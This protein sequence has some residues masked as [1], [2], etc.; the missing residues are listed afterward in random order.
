MR[1]YHTALSNRVSHGVVIAVTFVILCSTHS[2]SA[3]RFTWKA[4]LD[5]H[6]GVATSHECSCW[7]LQDDFRMTDR[8]V[9]KI[10][11]DFVAS[12]AGFLC[13]GTVTFGLLQ[14]RLDR[15]KQTTSLH[16]RGVPQLSILTFGAAHHHRSP[17]EWDIPIC[18]SWLARPDPNTRHSSGGCLRFKIRRQWQEEE[19]KRKFHLESQIVGY[20]PWLAGEAPVSSIRK[21]LYLNTQS[22]IHAYVTYRFH[23]EWRRQILLAERRES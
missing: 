18:T 19:P 14:T 20:H 5:R 16:F 23:R 1:R 12:W 11:E 7:S 6:T 10:S 3:E 9:R 17:G 13:R 21:F 22:R 2:C 15:S 8:L 4:D